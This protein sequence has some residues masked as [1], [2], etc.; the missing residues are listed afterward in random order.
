LFNLRQ[1]RPRHIVSPNCGV[2]TLGLQ[3]VI[4]KCEA[5]GRAP[6]QAVEMLGDPG[7]KW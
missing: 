4:L 6:L 7:F 5:S 3:E 1:S 2:L